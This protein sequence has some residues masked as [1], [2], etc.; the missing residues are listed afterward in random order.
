MVFFAVSCARM[1]LVVQTRMKTTNETSP[2]ALERIEEF[3]GL[4]MTFWLII[5]ADNHPSKDA[6][7]SINCLKSK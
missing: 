4:F 2:V 7:I 3:T 5:C 6:N 1:D